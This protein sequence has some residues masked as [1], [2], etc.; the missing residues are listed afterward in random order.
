MGSNRADALNA[1]LKNIYDKRKPE[2]LQNR[3][4]VTWNKLKKSALK[5]MGNGCFGAAISSGN[6]KGLGAQNELEALR[7]AGTQ[8]ADQ[9]SVTPRVITDTIELSGLYMEVSKGNDA[10]FADG[11]VLQMDEG[12][13]DAQ[14][15]LNA[16]LFRDGTGLIGRVNGAV[17]ASTTVTVDAAILSHFQYGEPLDI[18]D[19]AGTIGSLGTKQ[20]SGVTIS[21]I[22]LSAGTIELASAQT[23]DDDG[24]IFRQSVADNTATGKE[25]SG[26]P[27]ITDDGTDSS[28]Y[29]GVTRTG[30]GYVAA[31]K[32]LEIAMSSANLSD[33]AMQK[34]V[35]RQLVYS[36]KKASAV[37]SSTSQY[38]KYLTSTLPQVRYEK[39]ETR[40][41][42]VTSVPTWNGMPWLVDTDCGNDEV[43]FLNFDYIEK[44]EVYDLKYDST[45]GKILK[46]KD[47]KDSFYAYAKYY[48]NVGTR[49]PRAA[50]IRLTGLA[51]ATF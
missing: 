7:T 24:Y 19:S 32:G 29:E 34:A 26:L 50:A 15:E 41:S 28:T 38:R 37:V 36:G 23:I 12:L 1:E 2:Q 6:Q 3:E 17:T 18:Y 45:N 49:N 25:I 31:W 40:D 43:Y 46:N 14:K 13:S 48:G 47:G 4:C 22:D 5:P 33:D 21:D 39:G 11:L 8:T 35:A 27:L 30:S 16:Q 10:S 44:F 20:V 9:W 42:G 51:E